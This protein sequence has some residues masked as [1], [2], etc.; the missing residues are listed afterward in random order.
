V[1]SRRGLP[2]Q[3]SIAG[4]ALSKRIYREQCRSIRAVIDSLG[5]VAFSL[6]EST[7]TKYR[8]DV[9]NWSIFSPP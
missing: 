1:P 6:S 2:P 8:Q 5:L 3:P 9:T 7:T 4:S